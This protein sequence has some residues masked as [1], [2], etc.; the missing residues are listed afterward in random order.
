MERWDGIGEGKDIKYLHIYVH[1]YIPTLLFKV[2]MVKWLLAVSMSQLLR[3]AGSGLVG[4]CCSLHSH[5]RLSTLSFITHDQE[6]I[7]Q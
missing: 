5:L 7:S 6:H 2:E 3:T 1:T 4:C